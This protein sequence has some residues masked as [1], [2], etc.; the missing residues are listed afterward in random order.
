MGYAI[1]TES[2]RMVAWIP[3][4]WKDLEPEWEG[5]VAG[6]ELY[7][8]DGDDGT[9]YS[10]ETSNVAAQNPDVV[11]DLMAQLK[12]AQKFNAKACEGVSRTCSRLD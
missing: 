1:R 8:H 5:Q 10:F 11:V 7:D 4:N 3:F 6:V 12:Q 2:W 9:V